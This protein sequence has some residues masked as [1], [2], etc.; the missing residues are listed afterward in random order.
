MI[1]KKEI[2]LVKPE[3][4]TKPGRIGWSG[5][6]V[7]KINRETQEH[8]SF[9]N[10]DLET[11]IRRAL[12]E[13]PILEY[14]PK[15]QFQENPRV[16]E[17]IIFRS[18]VSKL[19]SD[20]NVRIRST[21]LSP[22]ISVI[23]RGMSEAE[24]EPYLKLKR[25]T[26]EKYIR[27][28]NGDI[29]HNIFRCEVYSDKIIETR[30]EER[31]K[32]GHKKSNNYSVKTTE[33]TSGNHNEKPSNIKPEIGNNEL[34]PTTQYPQFCQDPHSGQFYYSYDCINWFPY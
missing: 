15:N 27:K 20:M 5:N 4:A 16:N 25:E 1:L 2:Q 21:L 14:T 13:N 22:I 10:M 7:F 17:F 26:Q 29:K 3:D 32:D 34:P 33:R 23:W 12:R 9:S 8:I 11:T 24:K 30:Y 19:V 31:R 18:H 6:S 28:A